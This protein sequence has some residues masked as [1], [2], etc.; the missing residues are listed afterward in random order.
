MRKS[1]CSIIAIA[2]IAA[3]VIIILAMV[4]PAQFWWYVLA[5]ALICGGIWLCR[6]GKK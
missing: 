1:P 3:G 4:L 6:C 5:V 2:A